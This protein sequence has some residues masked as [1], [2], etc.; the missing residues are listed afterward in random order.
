MNQDPEVCSCPPDAVR[1]LRGDRRLVAVF[2][3]PD[4]E[5][6]VG[7]LLAKYAAQG[8]D[9]ALV[10]LTRG[11]NGV[12]AES[13]LPP[14]DELATARAVELREACALLGIRTLVPLAFPDGLREFEQFRAQEPRADMLERTRAIREVLEPLLRTLDPTHVI[15]FGPEGWSGHIDHRICSA[16]TTEIVQQMVGVRLFYV[17]IPT[18]APV[19]AQGEP[20][21]EAAFAHNHCVQQ[22]YLTHVIDLGDY[23]DVQIRAML[24]HV[25]QFPDHQATLELATARYITLLGRKCY[26][27][28]ALPVAP[29]RGDL[30]D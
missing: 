24:C 28:E 27:R 3:H 15:T 30:F 14:G 19:Q 26:L 1:P 21:L 12:H 8:V 11:E 29:E 7:G 4:D 10:V 9:T 18:S 2:A 17:A 6:V 13:T 20:A 22:P 25:S 5:S 16:V 23:V